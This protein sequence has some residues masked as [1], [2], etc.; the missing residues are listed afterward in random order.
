MPEL[1]KAGVVLGFARA[2]TAAPIMFGRLTG[3]ARRV[4]SLAVKV[5]DVTRKG[6]RRCAQERVSFF[7]RDV[8]AEAV[9]ESGRTLLEVQTTRRALCGCGQPMGYKD[10]VFVIVAA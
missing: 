8:G 7:M 1:F 3:I 4:E 9:D 2:D 6:C 5:G 10:I